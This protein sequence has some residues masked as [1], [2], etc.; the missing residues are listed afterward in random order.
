[1]MFRLILTEK[2]RY[3]RHVSAEAR[4]IISK[5]M[6]KNPDRRLGSVSDVDEVMEQP[7]FAPIDWSDLQRKRITPPFKPEVSVVLAII[8]SDTVIYNITLSSTVDR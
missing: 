6:N 1:M 7:F 3:P 8:T 5:L 4:E 2:L